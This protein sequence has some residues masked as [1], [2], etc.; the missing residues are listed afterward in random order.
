MKIPTPILNPV[1]K[2]RKYKKLH[3]KNVAKTDQMK[4]IMMPVRKAIQFNAINPI[5]FF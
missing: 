5:K 4:K 2:G 1:K 3:N